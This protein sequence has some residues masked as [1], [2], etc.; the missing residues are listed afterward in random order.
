MCNN[1]SRQFPYA[2]G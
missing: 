1:D 2:K